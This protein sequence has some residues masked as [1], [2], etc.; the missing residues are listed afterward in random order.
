MVQLLHKVVQVQ[1]E[2]FLTQMNFNGTDSFTAKANDGEL[3]NW[4]QLLHYS[5]AVNDLPIAND[6]TF[7]ANEDNDVTIV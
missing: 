2:H 7:T 6:Q 1:L 3:D 5:A 4:L